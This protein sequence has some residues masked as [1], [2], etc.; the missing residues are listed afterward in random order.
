MGNRFKKDGL[1]ADP[2]INAQKFDGLMYAYIFGDKLK[3]ADECIAKKL[4]KVDDAGVL[5]RVKNVKKSYSK[6]IKKDN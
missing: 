6:K 1:S 4:L 5:R 2:E 3:A